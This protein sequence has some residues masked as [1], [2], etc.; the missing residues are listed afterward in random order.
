M[1]RSLI[2]LFVAVFGLISALLELTIRLVQLATAG[3]DR[4]AQ[5]LQTPVRQGVI[6]VAKPAATVPKPNDAEERL[7][8]ALTGPSLQFSIRQSRAFAATVRARL[9]REPIDVL[10]REGIASLSS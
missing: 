2:R 1:K 5:R 6:E 9:D 10:V 8:S 4:L 3:V 7:V